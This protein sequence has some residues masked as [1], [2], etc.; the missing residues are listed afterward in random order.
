MFDGL[1]R[2]LFGEG[3]LLRVRSLTTLTI[4]GGIVYLTATEIVPPAALVA[5]AGIAIK[6][7]FDSRSGV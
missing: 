2:G 5:L 1:M 4:V 7:Y 6:F 3:G